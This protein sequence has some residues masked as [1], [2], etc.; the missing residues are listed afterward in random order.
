MN[1]MS[2]MKKYATPE[3]TVTELKVEDV[4]TLSLNKSV[5]LDIEAEWL[6]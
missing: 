6:E 2:E 4:I 5:A 1:L 3:A